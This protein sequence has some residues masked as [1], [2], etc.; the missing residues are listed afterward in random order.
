M[1]TKADRSTNAQDR[2]STNSVTSAGT[3]KL[4]GPR[5]VSGQ[6]AAARMTPFLASV[7]TIQF[8]VGPRPTARAPIRCSSLRDSHQSQ[9]R[10]SRMVVTL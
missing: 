2:A 6:Y 1:P 8:G 4:A 3:W 10:F 7:M 5:C 9:R